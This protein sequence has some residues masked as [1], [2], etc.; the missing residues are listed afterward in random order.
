[1]T[2]WVY[3]DFGKWSWNLKRSGR[4]TVYFIHTTPDA[5]FAAAN[6]TRYEL[7][8]S[9]GCVHI[10]PEDRDEMVS[11]GYLQAGTEVEVMPYGTMGPPR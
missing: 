8:Q 7:E 3:N 9:H 1:M 2:A 10:K 11:R 4:R 5:E 6:N